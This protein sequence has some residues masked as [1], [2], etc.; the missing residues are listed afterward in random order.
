MNRFLLMLLAVAAI[1]AGPAHAQE[2]AN[3]YVEGEV[4]VRYHEGSA[5]QSAVASRY[6]GLRMVSTIP[7]RRGTRTRNVHLLR[8]DGATTAE[9]VKLLR[10]DPEVEIVE[11]NYRYRAQQLT[12]DDPRFDELW[13]LTRIGAPDAW[14]TQTGSSDV[15]VAI[16]DSGI[17]YNHADL[18]A[19]MWT[20][21]GAASCTG[22][23]P[24][25]TTWV[26]N[27]IHGYDFA[28]DDDGNDDADPMDS[29]GHGTHVAGTV[30]AVGNNGTGVVGVNWQAALLAVKM[31]RPDGFFYSSD[32]LQGMEY[33]QALA[34][35]CGVNI[36]AANA[37]YGGAGTG[38]TLIRDA[39]EALGDAGVIFVAAAGNDA[40]D[41]D[42]VPYRPAGYD[43][44]N[45][46]AVA[47]IDTADELSSF[48]NYG[49]ESVHLAAPGSGILS[50]ATVGMVTHEDDDYSATVFTF[51]PTISGELVA[52]MYHCGL[53]LEPGDCPAEV[54]GNIALVERGNIN[55][56]EKVAN[57]QVAGAI[58]V[59]IY[60]S[61][62]GGEAPINGTLGEPGDWLPTLGVARSVGLALRDLNAPELTLSTP[63]G[64]AFSNGTSMATPHVT[65]AIALMAAQ[66]PGE[67]VAQ[68][69]ERLLA[70]TEQLPALTDTTRSGG[71][72]NLRQ[73]FAAV[74]TLPPVRPG[75]PV[76]VR[77]APDA[78][79]VTWEDRSTH[80]TSF[81]VERAAG[82]GAFI[83]VATVAASTTT[84]A[85]TGLTT[86][87]SYRWRVRAVGPGGSS[88][89]SPEASIGPALQSGSVING[90][91]GLQE[92][93]VHTIFAGANR[94]RLRATI[95]ELTDDGDLYLRQGSI[96]TLGTFDCQSVN[97]STIPDS[98]TVNNSGDNT[99][100]IGVYGFQATNY[101]LT[102]WLSPLA[103]DGLTATPVAGLSIEL[104]WTHDGG[105]AGFRV[106]RRSGAGSFTEI[107]ALAAGTT[108]YLDASLTEGT[109][110][111]Y[112]VQAHNPADDAPW[113]EEVSA[114]AFQNPPVLPPALENFSIVSPAA[115]TVELNWDAAAS[116]T[117]G[118]R[119]QRRTGTGAF[120]TIAELGPLSSSHTDAGVAAGRYGYRLVAFNNAGSTATATLE[121]DVY[122]A[123][124]VT[125]SE[126][127]PVTEATATG[128]QFALEVTGGSGDFTVTVLPSFDAGAVG[129][130]SAQGGGWLF[131]APATGAFAGLYRVV[132]ED[133][134]TGREQTV[135]VTVPLVV[136]RDLAVYR[137][138]VDTIDVEVRGGSPGMV[139]VL[140]VQEDGAPVA[141]STVTSNPAANAA[142][143]GNPATATLLVNGTHD[144]AV[145]I[146][147]D[148]TRTGRSATFDIV[149]AV[150]LSGQTIDRFGAPVVGATI[151]A[152]AHPGPAALPWVATSGAG[153]AFAISLPSPA[154]AAYQLTASAAGFLDASVAA[155]TCLSGCVIVLDVADHELSGTVGPMF[156]GETADIVL[157]Y[158]NGGGEQDD[159]RR[160]VTA[161]VNGE[162]VFTFPLDVRLDYLRLEVTATGYLATEDDNGGAGWN[163]AGA[164]ITDVRLD[165]VPTT[166][167]I[168]ALSVGASATLTAATL[169]ARVDTAGRDTRVWFQYGVAAPTIN[170]AETFLDAGGTVEVNRTIAGLTCSTTYQFRVLAENDW[171]ETATSATASFTTQT[172]AVT[173]PPTPPRSGGGS[174]GVF[175]LLGLLAF[176]GAAFRRRGRRASA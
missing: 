168:D 45:I 163:P 141:S 160:T 28:A 39:I 99:W 107:A 15:V 112:R 24:Q 175:T 21:P 72:L 153:G 94:A 62:A 55:F 176:W 171:G 58:A 17:D 146:A 30:A 2:R 65:G 67:S 26:N 18:A 96:P 1:A 164:D 20:T 127:E 33:V 76:A 104:D 97:S 152:A 29:D 130:I 34:E 109:T 131:T 40:V 117:A 139:P 43:L 75:T 19:N 106:Q 74:A 59:V 114:T 50:A 138:G 38:S 60:N 101:Q 46:V 56:S 42:V 145:V 122:D 161:A 83:E 172:C 31:M 159:L 143:D 105:A 14:A 135:D 16:L 95:N 11:P 22:L 69:V 118:V 108:E 3:D 167:G 111:T 166:P 144:D 86:N 85:Q 10:A 129:A 57:A 66:F 87:A 123:V 157:V 162:S 61:V 78:A 170:S 44:G 103:V 148:T 41:S 13:G 174:I 126:G 53:L 137:A 25:Q 81:V 125:D 90:F 8:S 37:S 156:P 63:G 128:G 51:S 173:T 119:V 48:S 80:T 71:L 92:W 169:S 70:S 82:A 158:D 77:T 115:N 142:A 79:Q 154:T 133:D 121:I 54:A 165:L 102:V 32:Q 88:A 151:L 150:T 36:V 134:V 4:L 147:T 27:G 155:S 89:W 68:R 49:L 110:Y 93:D 116:D 23:T 100:F 47:S 7:V 9:L 113:S 120:A 91:V 5:A 12:P 132:V 98:C 6:P 84:L 64:Y 124:V 73:L 52:E 149:A 136:T 35:N 140:A